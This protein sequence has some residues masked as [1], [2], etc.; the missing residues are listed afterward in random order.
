MYDYQKRESFPY[1]NSFVCVTGGC[2]EAIL[3][4]RH[5][6]IW[7][8]VSV[9]GCDFITSISPVMCVARSGVVCGDIV[10]IGGL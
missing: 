9:S 1:E 6:H 5:A 8:C 4:G 2:S 3:V 10:S 7:P